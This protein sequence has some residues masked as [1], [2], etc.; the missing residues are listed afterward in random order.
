MPPNVDVLHFRKYTGD[1]LDTVVE[2]S[3][4]CLAPILD[5]ELYDACN[6]AKVEYVRNLI[7]IRTEETDKDSS[8]HITYRKEYY[9]VLDFIFNDKNTAHYGS[10]FEL[11]MESL[12]GI[13]YEKA[14][15]SYEE[16][17]CSLLVTAM[18]KG[19]GKIIENL[20]TCKQYLYIDAKDYMGNT[21][22]HYTILENG[23][24][25]Q[26]FAKIFI[27]N[28]A[29]MNI[30]NNDGI[31]VIDI[32]NPNTIEDILNE[33]ISES[34]SSNNRRND[35]YKLEMDISIF[36]HKESLKTKNET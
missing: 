36:S 26:T 7:K 16:A 20:M 33:C 17:H 31:C 29:S 9:K 18:R 19:Y 27:R 11:I 4:L 6:S 24:L 21:A 13:S 35:N 12:K 3:A 34:D 30:R 28:G 32:I 23:L 14:C 8:G 1:T 5:K 2:M 22:L 10:L 15:L 25:N